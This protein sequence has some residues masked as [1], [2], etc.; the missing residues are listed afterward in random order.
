[1]I[2]RPRRTRALLALALAAAACSQ[3][4]PSGP[5]SNRAPQIR[6]VT[7]TPPVV[8]VGG[9]ATVVVDATDPDGDALFFRYDVLA[10]TITP[11]PANGAR[12]TYTNDGTPRT[13]DALTVTVLDASSA[14]TRTSA[15]IVLQ[16]NRAPSVEIVAPTSSCHPPCALTVE[17]VASDPDND[18]LQYVWSGCAVGTGPRAQ[19]QVSHA[20]PTIAAVLVFDDRGGVQSTTLTVEGTNQ[21]PR[22]TRQFNP[23]IPGFFG[24]IIDYTD[25]GDAACGWQG[26]CT[27]TH[28][29]PQGYNVTCYGGPC[30]MDFTCT[31]R[32]GAA[33]S[34]RFDLAR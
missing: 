12:A 8:P 13:G 1:M 33:N 28:T 2:A 23:S 11:D 18:S 31:D 9:T 26:S 15:A 19:C 20:G 24:V 14:S 32:F 34:V 5:A 16:S 7:V 4:G 10:G 27:C 25:D 22:L 30:F 17:A 6:S 3:D 29:L 21:P